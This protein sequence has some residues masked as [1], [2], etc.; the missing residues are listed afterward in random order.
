MAETELMVHTDKT[1]A[2]I[3]ASDEE[4]D[5]FIAKIK[6]EVAQF[7]PDTSTGTGRKA[8]ASLAYKVARTKTAIDEAGK[9]LT[10]EAKKQIDK[11]NETRRRMRSELDALRDAARA[12]LSRWEEAEAKRIAYY[13]GEIESMAAAARVEAGT[14]SDDI[15]TRLDELSMVLITP[16]WA[17]F[18]A[19]GLRIHKE[20]TER[21]QRAL[22]DA[23]K[24][25]AEAAELARLR[26]EAEKREREEAE[27]QAE[28][29]RQA[30]I[31][32]EAERLEKEREELR[33]KE[34]AAAEAER[35]AERERLEEEKRAAELEA[36][37]LEQARLRAVE[38][39]KAAEARAARAAQEERERI[40]AEQAEKERAEREAAEK[41]RADNAYRAKAFDAAA[42][43]IVRAGHI[44][45]EAAQAILSEI[46]AGRVPHVEMKL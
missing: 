21:L 37:A 1:P 10:E 42:E 28:E 3:A 33:Q 19:Q 46:E 31:R 2:Q 22:A 32:A 17:E 38:E 26:E 45:N 15:Q 13:E 14:S 40:E 4:C 39:Q 20:A 23:K 36:E 6:E 35:Q 43:A 12:P 41:R 29:K 16:K 11:V 18:E 9:K 7:E 24:A 8:I 34:L 30:E 25:E 27:R 5:A 44:S